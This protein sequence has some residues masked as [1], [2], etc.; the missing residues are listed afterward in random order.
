[1]AVLRSEARPGPTTVPKV[2]VSPVP[3]A[4]MRVTFLQPVLPVTSLE[5]ME[6]AAEP[7]VYQVLVECFVDKTVK[8]G[9]SLGELGEGNMKSY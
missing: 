1:M 9:I 4:K 6:P 3:R 7:A 2:A 8:D 5:A